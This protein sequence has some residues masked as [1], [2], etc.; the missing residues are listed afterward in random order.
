MI[1]ATNLHLSHNERL[2]ATSHAIEP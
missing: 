2:L 1:V